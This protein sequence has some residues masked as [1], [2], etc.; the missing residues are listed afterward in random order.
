M[1]AF[2][3]CEHG[4]LSG[5][6]NAPEQDHTDQNSRRARGVRHWQIGQNL[7]KAHSNCA[8]VPHAEHVKLLEQH[9]QNAL[10]SS[11]LSCEIEGRK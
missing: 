8:H 5:C 7:F 10:S 1:R 3:T 11:C 2:A 4:Q 6:Q 9:E